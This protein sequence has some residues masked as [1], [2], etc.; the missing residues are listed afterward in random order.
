MNRERL[1]GVRGVQVKIGTSVGSL[2]IVFNCRSYVLSKSGLAH[3][4]E[5]HRHEKEFFD[6]VHVFATRDEAY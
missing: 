6:A 3:A 2:Q 5:A 4:W 1:I